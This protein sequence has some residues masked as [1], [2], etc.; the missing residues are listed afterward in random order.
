M[1]IAV[2]SD[3]HGFSLALDTVLNDLDATGPYDEIVVAGDLCAVGPD[4]HGVLATLRSGPFT[5]LQGNTDFDAAEE[6]RFG[7]N[8]SELRYVQQQVRQEG[9]DY[10]AGLPFSRRVTPPGGTSPDDDLL[11]VHANPNNLLDKLDPTASDRE[12][13]D[14]I[15]DVQFRALAF[16]HIHICYIRELGDRLLVDV[17]AVGNSKDG[18]LR[19]KYGVLTWN[20]NARHWDAEIRKLDYPLAET[21]DQILS[22]DLPD[23]NKV[24]RK[25]LKASY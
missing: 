4:P 8:D 14:V 6:A 16:G 21:E 25:L 23:P 15:G 5:V 19:C 18:D 11:I 12:L 3:I 24:L 9:I 22:S 10:L 13:L 1:R 17:S 20:E 7:S 2:M